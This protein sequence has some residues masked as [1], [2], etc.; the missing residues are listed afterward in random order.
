MSED[1]K[2]YSEEESNE[3]EEDEYDEN[4]KKVSFYLLVYLKK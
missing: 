4:G 2:N 3:E 1:E